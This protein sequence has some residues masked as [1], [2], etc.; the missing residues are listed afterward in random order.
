LISCALA[1]PVAATEAIEGLAEVIVEAGVSV[2]L[3]NVVAAVV[4]WAVAFQPVG[5]ELIL[6]VVA[7]ACFKYLVTVWVLDMVYVTVVV[8]VSDQSPPVGASARVAGV[9]ASRTAAT[10][11]VKRILV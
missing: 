7:L 1:A 2:G 5:C 8:V 10:A 6:L 4:V 9:R 3:L 11:V